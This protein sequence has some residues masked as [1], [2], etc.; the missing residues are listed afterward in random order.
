MRA[1]KRHLECD[2]PASLSFSEESTRHKKESGDNP[3]LQNAGM[4]THAQDP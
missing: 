1:A 4:I 3:A 2:G